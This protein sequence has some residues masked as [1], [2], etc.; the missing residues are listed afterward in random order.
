[1]NNLT[2]ERK[3][4]KV[5]V[6]GAA[7]TIG[8]AI[9]EQ[10][11]A[12]HE[13]IKVGKTSGQYQVDTSNIASVEALFDKVG[14]VDAVVVAAGDLYFGPLAELTPDSFAVGLQ[15]K[16][17]GQ[18]NVALVAQRRLN[19]NGSITLTSGIVS[20]DPIRYGAIASTVNAALDGFAR[21]AAIE[22]PRGIRI[23]MVSPTLVNES[24]EA[25]G[26][27]FHGFET[28]PVS[29]A[30]LAYSKSVEGLQT[31]QVYRVW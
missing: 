22:M 11:S 13:I 21:G 18:I 12:R 23:N 27:Y 25:Y 17:M 6:I 31:G 8:K 24:L 5:I 9:V 1:M 16:L 19:D 26:A 15:N 10:L 4:M 30:A 14:R 28:V 20:D 29:R 3:I 7:G 2:P